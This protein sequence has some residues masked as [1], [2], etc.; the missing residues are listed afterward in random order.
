MVP[1]IN[2]LLVQNGFRVSEIASQRE[3]LEEVFLR[4]TREA[5]LPKQS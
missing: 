4:L 1:D 2:A 5:R 3:S